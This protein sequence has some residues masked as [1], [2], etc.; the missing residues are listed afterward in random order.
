MCRIFGLVDGSLRREQ[1]EQLG[2]RM[3][4]L[5]HHGGPDGRCHRVTGS[6]PLGSTRLAI[7][8]PEHGWQPFTAHGWTV[9]FNGQLYNAEALREG[10]TQRGVRLRT[11]CDGEVL[12]HL[13]ARHGA[14]LH[15]YLDGMFA[16]AAHHAETGR[17][18]LLRDAAGVKPLY[19]FH[20]GERLGFASE[21]PAL[22]KLR[23]TRPRVDP[24]GLERYFRLKSAYGATP[25]PTRWGTPPP[26]RASCP[27]LPAPSSTG[28][29]GER[30]RSLWRSL[31]RRSRR[32]PCLRPRA[33]S[34]ANSQ[35]SSRR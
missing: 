10:L 34:G 4:D 16:I 7:S 30:R 24:D 29:P 9:V 12:P 22:L 14:A 5:L 20:H 6:T 25:I 18:L 17:L 28:R 3:C 23:R 26:S 1:L 15:P 2:R 31:C 13:L 8:D 32:C 19:L 35:R 21:I 11:R 33:T 27:C